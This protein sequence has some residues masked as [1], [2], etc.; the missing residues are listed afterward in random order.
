MIAGYLLRV[1]L[2]GWRQFCGAHGLQL[3]TYWDALPGEDVIRRADAITAALG[4]TP[5][6]L[7]D[8]LQEMGHQIPPPMT[9]DQVASRL[10][11]C[12]Q[13]LTDRRDGRS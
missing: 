7:V 9:A 6:Y 8:L 13:H 5:E 10:T 11:A 3:Q 2:D 1:S 4:L 12:L